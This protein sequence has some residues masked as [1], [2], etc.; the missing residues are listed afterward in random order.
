ML[1]EATYNTINATA[2]AIFRIKGSKFIAHIFTI[3]TENDFKNHL[4]QIKQQHPKANHHCYGLRLTTNRSVYKTSDDGEPAGSAGKPILNALLSADVT[5]CACV[6]T[7]YFGGTLLGVPGLI[8]AYKSA[9]E[10]AIHLAGI[11]T[12]EITEQ[13]TVKFDFEWM[14]IIQNLLKQHQAKIISIQQNEHCILTFVVTKTHAQN[15]IS[16]LLNEYP[17]KGNIRFIN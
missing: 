12:H 5:Q 17:L 6:V 13:H 15:L 4:L 3:E 2:E 1:F 16:K 7:R 11:S 9:T 14:H 8:N 10:M